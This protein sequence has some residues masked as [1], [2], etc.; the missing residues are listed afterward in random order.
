[1]CQNRGKVHQDI[2]TEKKIQEVWGYCYLMASTGIAAWRTKQLNYG[3][4]NPEGKLLYYQVQ[5]V[6]AK[7]HGF[8]KVR[9]FCPGCSCTDWKFIAFDHKGPRPKSHEGK[10]GITLAKTLRMENYPREIQLL[11]HNCNTGKEIFGGICPHHLPKKGQK[12]LKQ[13]GIPLGTIFE[14]GRKK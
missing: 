10:S 13:V 6:Y 5:L 8:S 14:R 3:L 1:M 2:K 9:C 11:C 4:T 12:I 7:R